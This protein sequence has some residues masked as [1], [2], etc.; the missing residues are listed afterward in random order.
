MTAEYWAQY[1]RGLGLHFDVGV[2]DEKSIVVQGVPALQV[3]D[4]ASVYIINISGEGRPRIREAVRC[5][6]FPVRRFDFLT[7]N[8]TENITGAFCGIHARKR[9]NLYCKLQNAV[10]L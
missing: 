3:N 1:I 9:Y 5:T 4:K 7:E 6:R 2:T 8:C 10:T